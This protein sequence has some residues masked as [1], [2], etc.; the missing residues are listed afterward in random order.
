VA[1]SVVVID[2][3]LRL[4]QVLEVFPISRS[5]WL[6]GVASGIYP[7]P[8]RMGKKAVGWLSSEIK[9]LIDSLQRTDEVDED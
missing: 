2:P 7:K 5:G 3:L 1:N 8:K 6:A 4:K 9:A